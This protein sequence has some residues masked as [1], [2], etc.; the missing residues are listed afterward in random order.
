VRQLKKTYR[1]ASYI[2]KKNGY[3]VGPYKIVEYIAEG[4]M[5]IIYKGIRE[6]INQHVAIK[7]LRPSLTTDSSFRQRFQNEAIL[8]GTLMNQNNPY[9]LRIISLEEITNESATEYYIVMEYIQEYKTVDGETVRSVGDYLKHIG[10]M[11]T[12]MVFKLFGQ[13]CEAIECAHS[14]HI[15]EKQTGIIHRDIKPANILITQH[16]NAVITDFGIS[17]IIGERR[18]YTRVGTIAGTVEYFPPE[19]II[20]K[21]NE[22]KTPSVQTDIYA[23]GVTLFEMCTGVA[24]FS[25]CTS[26]YEIMNIKVKGHFPPDGLSYD[27]EKYKPYQRIIEN[28]TARERQDRYAD[29]NTLLDEW[30]NIQSAGQDQLSD[31]PSDRERRKNLSKTGATKKFRSNKNWLAYVLI[32]FTVVVITGGAIFFHKTYQGIREEP[33]GFIYI[34]STPSDARVTVFQFSGS[35]VPV[36]ME[37]GEL[38]TPCKVSVPINGKYSVEVEKGS[39]KWRT[40]QF[41]KLSEKK[42]AETVSAVLGDPEKGRIAIAEKLLREGNIFT[43]N[44]MNAFSIFEELLGSADEG[45]RKSARKGLE[46]IVS[47]GRSYIQKKKYVKGEAILK[48][49]ASETTDQ[50]IQKKANVG[51][52]KLGDALLQTGISLFEKDDC[53][54]AVTFFKKS[55]KYIRGNGEVETWLQKARSTKGKLNVQSNPWAHVIIEKVDY[56][57]T[58]I[59]NIELLSGSYEIKMINNNADNPDMKE[60]EARVVI[61]KNSQTNLIVNGEDVNIISY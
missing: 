27:K 1:N 6:S 19:L 24:P 38:K 28:C 33:S 2:M 46:K 59:G 54:R 44:E 52:E 18:G 4:G 17:K 32:F 10:S 43:P 57:I 58:P 34:T 61:K 11:P 56:G 9:I 3:H 55:Q 13:T 30:Q 25:A 14:L 21:D 7:Q 40:Q 29:I 51:L 42:P 16:E 41:V 12:Q 22:M 35:S 50:E 5:G 53:K 48:K 8:M 37:L 31:I 26:E 45:T 20:A 23:L 49:I 15:S 60:R 36:R 39:N 47:S